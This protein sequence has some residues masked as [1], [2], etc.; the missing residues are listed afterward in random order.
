M[1]SA[2]ES[3]SVIPAPTGDHPVT[4]RGE[5]SIGTILVH[6]GRLTLEDAERIL[7]RQREQGERFG[8]AAV[9][10][11]LLTQADIDFALARQ[12]DSPYLVRGESRVSEDIIAAYAPHSPQMAAI[13]SLRSH[14][15][16][17][18]FDGEPSHKLLAIVSAEPKEGRSFVAA[19]LAVAFSQLGQKTLLID[20]DM[21]KPTQHLLFG[22]DNGSGLSSVLSDRAEAPEVSTAIPGLPGLWL[23]PAGVIPPNPL[24]LLARPRFPRL[25]QE[26]TR[27]FD[28]ILLDS[29]P[30]AEHV[31]AQTIAVRAGAAIIVARKNFTRIWR[32]RGV[33]DKV[34]HA[35]TVIIGTVLN[36][37]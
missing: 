19:N 4:A 30:A 26:L 37:Y 3:V 35:S 15:M 27:E 12:F 16:L 24:E 23:L 25:L 28:I 29:P 9:E 11:G 18:W 33:S 1:K 13:T 6:A 36:D 2:A 14:L 10:L 20:A 31:D 34:A 17:R 7:Q 21:R 32:V 5:R 8:D 22:T